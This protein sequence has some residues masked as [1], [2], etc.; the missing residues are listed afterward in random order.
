MRRKIYHLNGGTLR[1]ATERLAGTGKRLWRRGYFVSHCL[2]IETDDGLALVETGIARPQS[3]A[4]QPYALALRA[5]GATFHNAERIAHQVSALGYEPDDVT[6]IVLTHLDM[7]NCGGLVDFPQAVVHVHGGEFLGAGIPSRRVRYS[8]QGHEPHW[9]VY[10]DFPEDWFGL[11]GATVLKT[12][13]YHILL[14]Q[15]P[16]FS[17]GHC[18]VA[19]STTEGWLL[20]CGNAFFNRGVLRWIVGHDVT[21]MISTQNTLS[22][23]AVNY[24]ESVRIIRGHNAA[25]F[26]YCLNYTSYLGRSVQPALYSSQDSAMVLAK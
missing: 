24:G 22:E 14:V 3:L 9:Q 16:G 4:A 8:L 7:D 26:S 11:N 23:L 1:F 25:E 21:L 13:D 19:V 12:P 20:H 5:L 10:R 2:L 17:Q 15:L 18:G 6:H